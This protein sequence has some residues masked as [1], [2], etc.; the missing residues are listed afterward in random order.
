MTGA[1]LLL[2]QIHPSFVQEGRV[3]SQAFKPMPKDNGLLSVYDGDLIAPAEAWDHYARGLGHL[4]VGAM[5]VTVD[6]CAGEQLAARPDPEPFDEH[7]VV[8]FTLHAPKDFEK[9]AKKLKAIATVRG[10]LHQP[11]T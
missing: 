5:A 7:A 3:T 10:W 8:D 6:E 4:S 11:N 1:T 2:R 9:K